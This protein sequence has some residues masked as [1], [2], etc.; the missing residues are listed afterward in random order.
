MTF[1]QDGVQ[2]FK[3]CE[4][5]CLSP[6]EVKNTF[7]KSVHARVAVCAA[8]RV[9]VQHVS[10]GDVAPVASIQRTR[11]FPCHSCLPTGLVPYSQ[12]IGSLVFS[13]SSKFWLLANSCMECQTQK[14]FIAIS[15]LSNLTKRCLLNAFSIKHSLIL[16]ILKIN[17]KQFLEF[18]NSLKH[19]VYWQYYLKA[20]GN[21]KV[22]TSFTIS[23]RE[24]FNRTVLI[25]AKV[26]VNHCTVSI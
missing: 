10:T 12:R 26:L 4:M 9:L 14:C 6:V 3:M 22:F 21:V 5:F 19:H 13:G 25:V 7:L 23:Q 17:F 18:L 15:S 1:S 20:L 11:R 24:S 16:I 2:S 8:S